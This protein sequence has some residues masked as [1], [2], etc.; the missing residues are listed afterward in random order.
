[1]CNASFTQMKLP[2]RSKMTIVLPLL[3]KR[4]LDPNDPASYR[5]ISNLSFVSK[6]IEKVVDTRLTDHVHK[7]HLLPVLQSSSPF[8]S[9]ETEIA[10]IL[11][12]MIGAVDQG[13]VGALMLPDLSAAFDTVD[14]QILIQVLQMRF[15][16]SGKALDWLADYFSGRCQVVRAGG[17]DSENS[18]CSPRRCSTR[19]SPCPK[20]IS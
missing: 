19:I 16:V 13:H 20:G 12:D 3:K 9:T 11:N 8:H 1:M 15:G 18:A 14:H 5:P 4:T 17:T 2:S 6:V 7:H 10:Y